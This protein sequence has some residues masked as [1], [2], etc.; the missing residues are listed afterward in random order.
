MANTFSSPRFFAAAL[1]LAALA[2]APASA[3]DADAAGRTAVLASG[4][5]FC[6][7][8]VSADAE[9]QRALPGTEPPGLVAAKASGARPDGG[10]AERS[11]LQ[12]RAAGAERGPANETV[13]AAALVRWGQ[14]VETAAGPQLLLADG[15]LLVARPTAIDEGKLVVRSDLFGNVT[16]PAGAVAAILLHPPADRERRD[17]AIA[18]ALGTADANSPDGPPA[19]DAAPAGERRDRV[20]LE[21]G[22][23]LVGT[24]GAWHDERIKI[25][26]DAGPLELETDQVTAVQFGSR[27]PTGE[28][29]AAKPLK[30][31]VGWRDGSRLVA[32][33]LT[34]R[35]ADTRTTLS[36][37]EPVVTLS[38]ETAAIT[39]L[40]T[41][42]GE[43]VY[44]SDLRPAGY[45][46]I[47]FLQ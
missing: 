25:D 45:K 33:A 8:F 31:V 13:P 40:Q 3:A 23:E 30:F 18:A 29:A 17:Q 9:N 2:S 12:F 44:L 24:L 21:N 1:L 15:G 47:P 6:G 36:G 42:G 38:A 34:T 20:L 26:T 14:F 10:G 37:V 46:H 22:D 32:S 35:G 19:A 5:T 41:L 39:A 7:Q 27:R 4:R 43:A 11:N 28:N 16:L